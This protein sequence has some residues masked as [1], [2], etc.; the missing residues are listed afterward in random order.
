LILGL[1]RRADVGNH[2]AGLA[3]ELLIGRY[4]LPAPKDPNCPVARHEAALL[5][6]AKNHLIE[7]G[8]VHRSEEFNRNILPLSLPLIQAIGHRMALEAAKETNIDSKIYT[9]Y[10]SGVIL[11]DSAWYTEQGGISRKAQREMEAQ[12]A[13]A[14]LPD[15]EKLVYETGAAPY[16]SAP[17][18]SDRLWNAF[19]SGL[20]TFAGEASSDIRASPVQ[21]T[22]L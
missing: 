22:D 21:S 9:L 4:Q 10:K 8:G 16:S 18:T 19:V 5:A 7:F 20:E 15:L 14:L 11:E 3:S 17:M 1:E 13:D 12:A 6:E 2:I